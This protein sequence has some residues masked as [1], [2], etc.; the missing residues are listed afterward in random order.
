MSNRVYTKFTRHIDNAKE[1]VSADHVNDVQSSI[2]DAERNINRLHDE[3]FLDKV[4]FSFD[5]NLFVNSLFANET[6]DRQYTDFTLSSHIQLNEN[7]RS[8]YVD[9]VSLSGELLTTRIHSS[10]GGGIP[11]NDFFLVTDEHIPTGASIKYYLVSDN[12]EV[13]PIKPN[14]VKPCHMFVRV[15]DVRIKAVLTK[16]ALGESPKVY[17]LSLMFF[18]PAVE[19][20]YGLTNPDLRRFDEVA[21]GLTVLVRDRAQE[22]RLVKIIEPKGYVELYYSATGQLD[23]VVTVNNSEGVRTTDTLNYGEYINSSNAAQTVLL[24]ILAKQEN[25]QALPNDITYTFF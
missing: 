21:M 3:Q 18:D 17:G 23:R 6:N 8:I 4:M 7:E 5:N 9:N 15:M 12:E 22:D 16:N 14:E 13:F 19:A 20:Q 2:S 24:S 10:V 11:L 1:P 25:L